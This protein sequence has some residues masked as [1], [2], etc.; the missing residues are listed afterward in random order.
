MTS[1]TQR[2]GASKPQ[3]K[4]P[5]R[6]RGTTTEGPRDIVITPEAVLF[7]A[8][9][10]NNQGSVY[11]CPWDPPVVCDSPIQLETGQT[12]PDGIAVSGNKVFWTEFLELGTVKVGT[13]TPDSSAFTGPAQ[14]L[15]IDLSYPVRIVAD[16]NSSFR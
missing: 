15:A 1:S 3:S 4:I 6:Q 14:T 7:T 12:Q 5:A 2:S 13:L 10:D 11:A 9:G 16:T 8:A